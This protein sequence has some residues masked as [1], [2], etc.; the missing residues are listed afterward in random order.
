MK[1]DLQLRG[2][3]LAQAKK[4]FQEFKENRQALAPITALK[5]FLCGETVSPPEILLYCTHRV[6]ERSRLTVAVTPGQIEILGAAITAR[7]PSSPH[8]AQSASEHR[9]T[10]TRPLEIGRTYKGCAH[11]GNSSLLH[12]QRCQTLSCWNGKTDEHCCPVC[13]NQSAIGGHGIEIGLETPE[14]DR[15]KALPGNSPKALP[16]ATRDPLLLTTKSKK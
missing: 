9:Q 3:S 5:R 14:M 8:N 2:Q 12:C 15:P 6:G 10:A 1:K 7:A 13:G 4:E 11:C 16:A